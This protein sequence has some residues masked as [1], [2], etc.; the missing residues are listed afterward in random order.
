MLINIAVATDR[1]EGHRLG[2]GAQIEGRGLNS[3]VGHRMG[4]KGGR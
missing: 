1:W 3:W 4:G 2:E